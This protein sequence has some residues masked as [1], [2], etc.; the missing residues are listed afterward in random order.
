MLVYCKLNPEK[1][2]ADGEPDFFCTFDNHELDIDRLFR[3]AGVAR[4]RR[5]FGNPCDT[6]LQVIK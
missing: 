5:S 1:R 4:L 2:N 6:D 3:D